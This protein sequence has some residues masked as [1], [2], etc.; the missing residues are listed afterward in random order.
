MKIVLT[1]TKFIQNSIYEFWDFCNKLIE[2]LGRWIRIIFGIHVPEEFFAKNQ[3]FPWQIKPFGFRRPYA[4][5]Q[6][7]L[8]T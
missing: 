2:Y 8:L 6:Q 4:R 3:L 7:Q 1:N 5:F